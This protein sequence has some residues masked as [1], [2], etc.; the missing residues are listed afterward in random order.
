MAA[1]TFCQIGCELIGAR[2]LLAFAMLTQGVGVHLLGAQQADAEQYQRDQ[3]F[4]QAEAAAAVKAVEIRDASL[5]PDILI[6]KF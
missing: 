3:H 1:Q 4:D 6:K 5:H 2:L